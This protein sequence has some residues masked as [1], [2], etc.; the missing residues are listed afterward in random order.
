MVLG[1]LTMSWVVILSCQEVLASIS[2][3]IHHVPPLKIPFISNGSTDS[4]SQVVGVLNQV[5]SQRAF[6]SCGKSAHYIV[7]GEKKDECSTSDLC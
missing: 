3:V 7:F 2:I 6:N 1:S 5:C 4:F